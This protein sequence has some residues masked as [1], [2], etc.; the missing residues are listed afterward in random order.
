MQ[1]NV[2]SIHMG[3]TIKVAVAGLTHGHV[4]GLINAWKKVPGAELVAVA[5]KTRLLGEVDGFEMKYVDW[6]EML[7]KEK[8]DA[9][10]VT[11]DNLESSEIA[12]YAL[13]KGIG[14][15]IEKPMAANAKD[16]DR[17][18]DAWRKGGATLMI[19]WPIAWSGWVQEFKRRLDEGEIGHPFFFR[20]RN[21]HGGPK[22]IGCGPEFVEWLYDEVKNGGGAIGDFCSYGAVV[23]RY[24]FGMPETVYCVRGNYTKDYK[25]SDDHAVCLLKYEKA[26]AELE[27]TWAT[28]VSDTGPSAV[29]HGSTGTLA[30]WGDKCELSVRGNRSEFLATKPEHTPATYFLEC[31]QT[32]KV[33]E[34]ILNPEIAA[35]A[36]RILDAG[37]ASSKS[38]CAERP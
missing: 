23:A 16:A 30:S 19:N 6:R 35:D 25:I 22:E 10:V 8:V 1:G 13:E 3:Q 27:G 9:L 29:V 26:A 4:G 12:S 36:C 5:D 20:F 24:L 33:P 28:A 21:G 14:C 15:L 37:I 38:G 17:M 32:G 31:L 2:T 34:G 18:L 11:S 7:D